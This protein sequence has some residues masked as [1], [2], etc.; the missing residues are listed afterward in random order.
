M[1]KK[2]V[3]EHA[4]QV[5]RPWNPWSA[6]HESR[7]LVCDTRE[8]EWK[9]SVINQMPR[10]LSFSIAAD[11]RYECFFPKDSERPSESASSKNRRRDQK[12]KLS[13]RRVNFGREILKNVTLRLKFNERFY[14][15]KL[16][17]LF[18]FLH[19]RF[20]STRFIYT[21]KIKKKNR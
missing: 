16:L 6:K 7:G 14:Y 10:D 4:L 3:A 11:A 17:S 9:F 1:K 15:F 12:S 5:I 2:R 19:A 20:K 8:H 18:V 21:Q 13:Q